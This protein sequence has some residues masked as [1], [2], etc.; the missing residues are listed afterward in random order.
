[1]LVEQD[2]QEWLEVDLGMNCLEAACHIS[3]VVVTSKKER[4]DPQ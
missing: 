4:I 2:W 1:L 3:I